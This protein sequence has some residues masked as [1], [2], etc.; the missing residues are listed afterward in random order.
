MTC[1]VLSSILQ[2]HLGVGVPVVRPLLCQGPPGAC[3]DLRRLA[4][5][6]VSREEADR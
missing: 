4:E 3:G 1:E 2:K 5:W 6:P